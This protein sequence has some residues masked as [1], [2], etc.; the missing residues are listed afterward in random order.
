[1]P[2]FYR[3]KLLLRHF[4]A[5]TFV[6]FALLGFSNAVLAQ[7]IVSPANAITNFCTGT[8]QILS[9]ITIAETA[10]TD[11]NTGSSVTFIITSPAN[12]QFDISA[13]PTVIITTTSSE[14]VLNGSPDFPSSTELRITFDV[15]GVASVDLFEITGLKIKA[16]A[17]SSSGNI[18]RSSGGSGG[19]TIVIAGQANTDSP[20]ISYG[21]VQ[22]VDPL[23]ITTQPSSHSACQNTG[24]FFTILASGAGLAYQWQVDDGLGGGFVDISAAGV[25]SYSGYTSSTLNIGN[26][27]GLD[28]YMYQVNVASTCAAIT[29]SSSAI[30][31]VDPIPVVTQQP[32]ISVCSAGSQS[33]ITFVNNVGAIAYNW[34]VTNFTA[35]GL[36][37]GSDVTDNIP[38]WT[39]PVNTSGT[40]ISGVATVTATKN[41]C[42]SSVMSFNITLKARP[43][44]T[45]P[46]AISVCSGAPVSV[47]WSSNVA[48]SVINW[49]NDTPSIGLGSSGA[50]DISFTSSPNTT[51]STIVA[52][53]SASASFNGCT[54]APV[55]FTIT[56]KPT[57]VVAQASNILQCPGFVQPAI[58]FTNNAG[59]IVYSWSVTNAAAIGVT[60]SGVTNTIPGFTFN[61]NNTGSDIV[62]VVTVTATLNSCTS[63]VM[64]FNITLKARPVLS[65]QTNV[66]YCPGEA[67]S[68]LFVSNASSSTIS[69]TNSNT[70][71]GIGSS[72]FGDLNF[73]AP[74]NN[75]PSD[76]VGN[77]SVLAS[78]N[79]CVS[80]PLNFIITIRPS[81]QFTITNTTTNICEGTSTNITLNSITS[82][83]VITLS[84]V[85]Y[86]GG[87]GTLSPGATFT[88]GQKITELIDNPTNTQI[89]VVYT[90]SVAANTCSNP[91]TQSQTVVVRPTP[92]ANASDAVICTG[93]NAIVLIDGSP[94]NVPGTTF[95]WI[96]TASSNVVGALN[97]NGSTINQ[98]LSLTNSIVGTVQYHITPSAS[99]CAGPVKTITVTINP[100]PTVNAGAD[101]QVCEPG[102]IPLSGTIGGAAI[103]GTWI[104]VSG[105]GTVSSSI[106]SGNVVTATYFVNPADVTNT[107]VLRLDTND[108]D[109][110]GPGGPCNLASDVLNI[111]INRAPT[112]T[113]PANY[114]V[115][116]PVSF[117]AMPISLSGTIGGSAT[118]G[119]W[120]VVTGNG[121]LSATN[122]SGSTVTAS[123]VIGVADVGTTVTFRLTSND[124]DGLG[125]C[126]VISK[127]INIHINPRVVLTAGPDLALCRDTPSIALQGSAT[128]APTTVQ[129][130]GGAGSYSNNASA[131]SN[132]SFNNSE[133]G[134]TFILTLTGA[135][136]DGSGPT[137]PC[138]SVSDQM[139]LTINALPVV[140]IFGLP[141]TV[142]ENIVS[143]PISGNQA[144]GL[145]TIT[146]ATSNIGSTSI[147]SGGT[148]QAFFDPSAVTLGFNTVIYSYT[149]PGN[150]CKNSASKGI[151]VNPVT[152]IDFALQYPC[153]GPSTCPFVP[154]NGSGEFELCSDVG[155][156]KLVGNPAAPTGLVPTNFVGV[157][158]NGAILQA[159]I[160]SIVI[161]GP[162]ADFFLNTNGL[163]SDTYLLQYNYTN[164]NGD[165]STPVTRAVK[166][167]ASPKAAILPPPNNCITASIIL[168]D[169]STMTSPNPYGGSITGWVWNFGDNT[170][171]SGSTT[172]HDYSAT[173]GPGVYSVNLEVTTFQGC[174][175]TSV[176]SLR[177]G[178]KPTV[179]FSWSAICTNDSTRYADLT[180]S[181]ISII[182]DYKWEF[183]DGD[184]LTGLAAANVP[185]GTNG[186]RT[187]GTVKNPKHNYVTTGTYP[188][189]L[190]VNTQDGC[191]NSITQSVFILTA[192][193]TVTPSPTNPYITDFEGG[194]G[195]NWIAEG[196]RTSPLAVRPEVF[197]PISWIHGT[198]SGATIKSASSGSVAWW[199]GY[200]LVTNG[201]PTYFDDEQSAV[202]GPCFD[203][204]NLKRPMIS[205]DY[206]VDAEKNIDGAVVEYST[207]GGLNWKLVGPL[208]G[209]VQR[210][211]GIN[212]Y[213]P[214]ATIVSN[215]GQ[216]LIGQYGWTDK[217]TGWKNGRFN[218][219]MV[220]ASQRSQ[221]RIR[222]AFS[223][224]AKNP[225]GDTY[226]G[227][228]FD[229]VYVGDKM[230]NVLVEHFTNSSLS[231]SVV[232]D[233]QIN[234]LYDDQIILRGV[235][236]FDNIQYHVAYPSADPLN[237]NNTDDPAARSLVYGIA[238][239]PAS[240]MD[241]IVDGIKFTGYFTDL[242][243]IEI[244]RRALKE[245]LFDLTLENVATASNNLISVKL[246][247]K[248]RK[249]INTPL[250]AQVVLVENQV[251]IFKNVMRKQLMGTGGETIT[252]PFNVNDV[253]IKSAT[254]VTI[255][256]PLVDPT[257]TKLI[258]YVQDKNTR[259][260]YQSVVIPIA[261]PFKQ[262]ILIT[263]LEDTVVPTTLN[264]IAVYPNPASGSF[265]FKLPENRTSEGFIWKLIDQ[266]GAT[267]KSGDFDNL[268]NNTKQVDISEFSNGIYFIMLSGPGG[269]VVYQKVVI[270][271]HN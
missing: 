187:S 168:K 94:E 210:D 232:A 206:W 73:T 260:I 207:D 26:V 271:N 13:I 120:S 153:A 178:P 195:G 149:N 118:T 176:L 27:N 234:K 122:I 11:F 28:T 229:N 130:T 56:I 180:N 109:G 235:S 236:D 167:F 15:N 231:V 265:Y 99:S 244:D 214:N 69:W 17:P 158:P 203:L 50:G 171:G 47:V 254:D 266:R 250:I 95:D 233:K 36:P 63:A 136:P 267:L 252:L 201:Q 90:F 86:G 164:S 4:S 216:Q 240:I 243:L 46:G 7:S 129:W 204:R 215:P 55:N 30:L 169:N 96:I 255:N 221:V 40:D 263:G 44:L 193:V 83:A 116:E 247:M 135:D 67:I 105:A 251:G 74:P 224:N 223:S 121:G 259:E 262:G 197:S 101:Y 61:A 19:G 53:I 198:P 205:L 183:G 20:G 31:T 5:H 65:A 104:K 9:S 268:S 34:S 49:T 12:F 10:P 211:Q 166:V 239:P 189:K 70:A 142:A 115:C 202:N 112:V 161:G 256:V 33:T 71:I 48:G 88:D 146:P 45:L 64:S 100:V 218:L 113:V 245:P 76:V 217:S 124:P 213:D 222:V 174:K 125:P 54:S 91:V 270:M 110:S 78:K 106:T 163:P 253:L 141:S 165:P 181:G 159:K 147:G 212:W 220:N 123:Y 242:N 85:N 23:S 190:T 177:V 191:T 246:T 108:P 248:A 37:S 35:L 8:D 264:G 60:A 140:N 24:T 186:G 173:S 199:T 150:G 79:G 241:G 133:V 128:G 127:D 269:S 102:S 84:A 72:G 51:G 209:E 43:V 175:S 172:T 160:S 75:T 62:G 196:L 139:N 89:S 154:V 145:F 225:A 184:I 66:V 38:G 42:I 25:P 228:A 227:F 103:S 52:N 226:D 138:P 58:V 182:N 1:M 93:Q 2:H 132:Y 200:N 170:F 208:A 59:A 131:T 32:D 249:A 137:G 22:S 219:D 188:S 230:R 134:T 80:N 81:P 107:I 92:S 14:L 39:F 151:V 155:S 126:T 3:T 257:K 238:Q 97:G 29:P 68:I 87:S 179:D 16:L 261:A 192:G 82:N 21:F 194:L 117:A 98:L 156:V 18:V 144:G 119:L 157:G 237:A 143:F 57:P 152:T 148:D 114:T 111:Q 6:L 185:A 41:G 162:N 77:I 258:A